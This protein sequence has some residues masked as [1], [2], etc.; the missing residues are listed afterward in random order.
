MKLVQ[1]VTVEFFETFSPN[2]S[3]V[4]LFGIWFRFCL[5]NSRVNTNYCSTLK[6]KEAQ[7]Y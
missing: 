4:S 6:K 5:K 2:H 7:V 3:L 1:Q